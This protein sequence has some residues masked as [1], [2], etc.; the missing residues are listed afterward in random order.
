[1]S[2]VHKDTIKI[3]VE[4]CL[5]LIE[6]LWGVLLYTL[7]LVLHSKRLILVGTQSV[8]RQNLNALYHIVLLEVIAKCAYILL[9]GAV[10]LHKNITQPERTTIILQP[11]RSLQSPM[12][13][14]A[15]IQFSGESA[16]DAI[17]SGCAGP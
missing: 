15:D 14:I 7:E 2:S 3:L 6:L 1:M 13:V 12:P 9:K 17:E 8:V 16:L 10:A 5:C 11:F 4:D